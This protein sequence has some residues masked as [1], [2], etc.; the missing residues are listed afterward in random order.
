[1]VRWTL[2][3]CLALLAGGIDSVHSA[4][5][6]D[7]VFAGG[8][9]TC[10]DTYVRGLVL[11]LRHDAANGSNAPQLALDPA[12]P[13]ALPRWQEIRSRCPEYAQVYQ[14][15]AD[16]LVQATDV[17]REVAPNMRP[18]I[19]NLGVLNA[20]V[21]RASALI[22][23][24]D[25]CISEVAQRQK[26]GPGGRRS[27]GGDVFAGTG[28][29][30][31]STPNEVFS[32]TGGDRGGGWG[33]S[34]GSTPLQPPATGPDDCPWPPDIDPARQDV[35]IP[36]VARINGA[37]A[38]FR[39]RVYLCRQR[40]GSLVPGGCPSVCYNDDGTPRRRPT[41]NSVPWVPVFHYFYFNG[42]NTPLDGAGRGNYRWD[43][44]MIRANLLDLDPKP[45]G[46][47]QRP[48]QPASLKVHPDERNL[49]N[50][51]TYNP[52]GTQPMFTRAGWCKDGGPP[53]NPIVRKLCEADKFRAA[54]AGG[55]APG[56][57]I[58]C[59][60][61]STL[62]MDSFASTE[63]EPAR[64]AG[65]IRRFY[66]TERPGEKH[67]FILIAH[68]Q[69]NFFA[70]GTGFLLAKDVN[71]PA[72]QFVFRNRLAMLS[73]GSPTSYE[74]LPPEFVQQKIRHYTRADDAINALH[75]LN[76]GALAKRPWPVS[77]A[78]P[79]LWPWN[80]YLL[81][82]KLVLAEQCHQGS[83]IVWCS[84]LLEVLGN[85]PFPLCTPEDN[86]V[87][88]H[89]LYIPLMNSHLIDNYLTDP[90]LTLP[91]KPVSPAVLS[92][93]PGVGTTPPFVPPPVLTEVRTGLRELKSTL[94]RSAATER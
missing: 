89:A 92:Y 82:S 32:G 16:L 54:Y 62:R 90:T 11:S 2:L 21:A 33:G 77:Q 85:D 29:G 87:C 31:R 80:R 17:L 30:T 39:Q 91:G 14:S 15:C 46:F 10:S 93:L 60:Y 88:N 70:E 66:E 57:I 38:A 40:R 59:L 22:G 47:Q 5:P 53:G 61:Q 83:K 58:E 64:L 51:E 35:R 45:V 37:Q 73:L 9:G 74:S 49:F 48:R 42:I 13:P 56:D 23:Q 55:M 34:D 68:S 63:I 72:G 25:E 75:S 41:Q 50:I 67:F 26:A 65:I 94:V 18:R 4:P 19:H 79:S 3:A 52:S 1:M 44:R 27:V 78:L 12:Y 24:A 7:E 28:Y 84:P 81:Q 20:G 8:S 76:A 69:G 43:F 86:P 71:S 36:L 6:A